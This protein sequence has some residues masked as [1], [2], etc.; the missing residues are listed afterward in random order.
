VTTQPFRTIALV[1]SAALRDDDDSVRYHL[2]SCDPDQLR[3]ICE[4]S[5]LAMAELVHQFV[6]AHAIHAALADAQGMARSEA[7]SERTPQ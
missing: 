2:A 4:A 5:V 6:P 7:T 3:A 1:V